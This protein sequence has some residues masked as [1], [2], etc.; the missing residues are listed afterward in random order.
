M[1]TINTQEDA[2]RIFQRIWKGRQARN[3]A[4]T[5]LTT[6]QLANYK[7]FLVGNDPVIDNI[8]RYAPV[9]GSIAVVGLSCARV[10]KIA[11]EIACKQIEVPKIFLVENSRQVI[12][13]WRS[14]KALAHKVGYAEEFAVEL[15]RFLAKNP[16]L[17]RSIANKFGKEGKIYPEQNLRGFFTEL[18]NLHGFSR[19]MEIIKRAVVIKQSWTSEALFEKLN[20]MF[21][22]LEIKNVVVYASN[23]VTYM[24]A[25]A[26]V[27]GAKQILKN[28]SLLNPLLAIHTVSCPVNET[29]SRWIPGN[30]CLITQHDSEYVYKLLALSQAIDIVITRYL[31]SSGTKAPQRMAV[32]QKLR[33]YAE[34]IGD[35]DKMLNEL[36][37]C[38]EETLHAHLTGSCWARIELTD[39]RLATLIQSQLLARE[40]ALHTPDFQPGPGARL[41]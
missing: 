16:Q 31:A 26:G 35:I 3:F 6:Q 9:T 1:K 19:V 11:C 14:L 32:V 20:N 8:E 34:N 30:V 13:F 27:A 25:V 39:S 29:L 2:A 40:Q 24:K 22:K 23:L 5:Q 38:Y 4:I 10:I 18:F 12:S 15:E 41:L 33:Q 36:Q 21:L 37:S 28:I 7:A 17:W